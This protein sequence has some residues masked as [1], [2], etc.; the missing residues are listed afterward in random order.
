VSTADGNVIGTTR[1]VDNSS[2]SCRFN[3]VLI[4]EGFRQ[5]ELG[6]FATVA[7]QFADT[8]FATPP[9]DDLR[10]A[11]NVYRI[12]VTSTD[13]GAD[14]PAACGGTG[15]TP[16]TY[17][18]ASFCNSGIQRL[19]LVNETTVRNVLSVE[20]PQWHQVIVIVNSP[21][22]GGAGGT[23]ATTSLTVA[24]P[25]WMR[26]AI[27][28]LGHSAFGLA[29]EYEYWKGCDS[30]ETTQ[31][32]Y[33][34]SE[35]AEPNV[36]ID[37]NRATIKWRD[38]ILPT[39]ALP[40]SSNADCTKCDPQPNP[41][42]GGTV[43]AFEGGRYFHCGIYRSEFN[44]MMR[45]LAPFC[46]VCRKRIRHV[47]EPFVRPDCSAPVFSA[48]PVWSCFVFAF[49]AVVM[50]IGLLLAEVALAG[51]CA[52]SRLALGSSS[53]RCRQLDAVRC[54]RKQV[55]FR[56]RN[57]ARGNNDPCLGL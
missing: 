9:I 47:L 12:D 13:S 51:L 18:D 33:P 53:N 15:A 24:P 52:A 34:G 3:L 49:A 16:A 45:N 35:P 2:P 27:H 14:D 48:L 36:T 43:G 30:G 7:R 44:C 22:W 31:N 21:I 6:Q 39:T 10:D 40:T 20:V 11:F 29:D 17:F 4:A 50:M 28:E 41:V 38:L 32:T 25:G 1:I 55:E 19:L 57:C 54:Q 37:T 5:N 26:I 46:A 23:I 42:T 56:V 8:L